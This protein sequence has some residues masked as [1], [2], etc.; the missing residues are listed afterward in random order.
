M[1]ERYPDD[2][3]LLALAAD[4]HT[5]AE[6]IPT[7]TTPYYLEFRRLMHRTLLAAA[8]ANDLR[9]Y[10]DG[11]LTV[12]IR[13]GRCVIAGSP[14]EFAGQTQLPLTPSQTVDLY[15]DAS[16]S[17]QQ[18][19]G[20]LP[21]SRSQFLPLA[22]ITTDASSIVAI[23]DLRGEAFL[24]APTAVLDGVTASADELNQALEGIGPTVTAANL[25]FLTDGSMLQSLH[26]HE[27][28]AW[29]TASSAWLTLLNVG[30]AGANVGLRF[31]LLNVLPAATEL[32]VDPANGFLTQSYD[33]QRYHMLGVTH[34]TATFNGP[35]TASATDRLLGPAPI[36]GSIARVDLSLGDNIASSDPSDGVVATVYRNGAAVCSTDPQIT[37]TD[38]AGFRS[39]SAGD[40]TPAT[41]LTDG[42]EQLQRG[43]ILTC[44]LTLTSS[45]TVSVD[46]R[47]AAVLVTIRPD[48]PA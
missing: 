16:G 48:G 26:H 24:A 40:G 19:S 1:T 22:R 11:D 39:T 8:R 35:I 13:A 31:D 38:G 5:G 2:A 32:A 21:A 17:P 9:V 20:G 47:H 4:A 29:D 41:V 37:S 14:I 30:A 36:A 45:G 46:P 23:V 12:G 42:T 34:M 28:F 44:D 43:D 27:R 33:G 15:L 10:P 18:S 7:G 3:E 25:E 6:Y